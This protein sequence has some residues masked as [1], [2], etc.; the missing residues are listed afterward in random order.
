[1]CREIPRRRP[2][3]HRGA[4]E[5]TTGQASIPWSAAPH[6][7]DLDSSIITLA[8]ALGDDPVELGERQVHH[9]TISGAHGLEGD[10]LAVADRLP[11]Q[12]ARHVR[13]RVLPAAAITV[14]VHAHVA[15]LEARPIHR[16]IDDEL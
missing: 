5:A 12:P 7:D 4:P 14:R 9:P 15:A 10:D 11:P 3:R 8:L 16:T 2:L 6:G 1:N 13:Q